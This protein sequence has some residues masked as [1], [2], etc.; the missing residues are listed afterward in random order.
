MS[1]TRKG[2]SYDST[3]KMI[4]CIF[5]NIRDGVEPGTIVARNEKFFA[6]KT[7]GPMTHTHLLVSPNRHIKNYADLSGSTDAALV[8]EMLEVGADHFF[9]LPGNNCLLLVRE[10]SFGHVC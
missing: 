3:G 1:T 8:R 10:K 5:C 2:V 4:S 9:S 7:T 6:F